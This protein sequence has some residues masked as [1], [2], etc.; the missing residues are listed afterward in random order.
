MDIYNNNSFESFKSIR[1][2]SV[3]YM[4]VI[5]D[6]AYYTNSD[7][8]YDIEN[9]NSY[10]CKKQIENIKSIKKERYERKQNK[11]SNDFFVKKFKRKL[12]N[13]KWMNE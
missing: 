1:N 12:K 2:K 9:L 6:Q 3:L 13:N 8:S 7:K 11:I 5:E 4:N 10:S